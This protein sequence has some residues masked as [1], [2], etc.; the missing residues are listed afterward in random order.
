MVSRF[1]KS[2]AK[3]VTTSRS[4]A[5][6]DSTDQLSSKISVIRKVTSETFSVMASESKV[7]IPPVATEIKRLSLP[8]RSVG[9]KEIVQQAICNRK[10]THPAFFIS[11]CR[12]A[13]QPLVRPQPQMPVIIVFDRS[14]HIPRKIITAMYRMKAVFLRIV[15]AQPASVCTSPHT[16]AFVYP[17]AQGRIRRKPSVLYPVLFA[18]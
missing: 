6:M 9:A 2:G 10:D 8:E 11:Q 13:C 12:Q 1:V 5:G 3:G 15:K 14:Y 17:E 18:P 16:A 7:L 4:S